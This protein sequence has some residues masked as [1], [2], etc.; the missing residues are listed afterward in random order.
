LVAWRLLLESYDALVNVLADELQAEHGLALTWYDVLVQLNEASGASL[1]MNELADAVLI[2]RSGLTRIV[3]GMAK[4]GLVRRQPARS[5]RRAINVLLT[6][7]GRDALQRAWP[8]HRRGIEEH[9]AR[10]IT[11]REAGTIA[12]ALGKV[13][14]VAREVRQ[15]RKSAAG[16]TA[17]GPARSRPRS[18]TGSTGSRK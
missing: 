9:F 3:D 6:G 10:H 18:R 14:A 4:A 5:D 15:A 13:L 16:G 7:R 12:V 11:D 17:I 1:R 2:S 8:A